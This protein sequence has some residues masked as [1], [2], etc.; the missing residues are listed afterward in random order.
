MPDALPTA[1]HPLTASV[2][3]TSAGRGASW[4]RVVVS[5]LLV[6]VALGWLLH[7]SKLDLA[8]VAR[9]LSAIS[10]W[11]IGLVFLGA[12]AEVALQAARFWTLFP[13]ETRPRPFQLLGVFAAGQIVNSIVPARSGDVL[14]VVLLRRTPAGARDG[15]GGLVGV[16]ASDK[17]VDFTAMFLVLASSGAALRA[18]LGRASVPPAWALVAGGVVLGALVAL[19]R[20]SRGG[21]IIA[22]LRVS[23][24]GFLRGCSALKHPPQLAGS[25]AFGLGAWLVE[26]VMLRV[27]CGALGH[28]ITYGGAVVA[29]LTL[30]LGIAIPVTIGN[31]GVFEAVL[32]FGLSLGGVPIE[33]AISAATLHH[34]LQ[35]AGVATWGL[36]TGFRFRASAAAA[37]AELPGGVVATPPDVSPRPAASGP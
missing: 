27:L 14:K 6:A 11:A 37:P 10:P 16:M 12:C 7:A 21:A 26:L 3:A 25:L 2:T 9:R 24:R 15:L 13:R 22:K 23:A 28:P 33:V 36:L 5:S 32:A 4:W 35:I 20:S 1:V 18:L 19:A 29:L 8:S 30:N 34:V 17:L 31:L